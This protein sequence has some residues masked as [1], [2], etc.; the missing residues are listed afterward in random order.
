[1]KINILETGNLKVAEV[2]SDKIIIGNVQDALD[3]MI[4]CNMEAIILKENNI[5]PR[6]LI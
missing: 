3:I 5:T 1:M 2:V 4:K 6:F